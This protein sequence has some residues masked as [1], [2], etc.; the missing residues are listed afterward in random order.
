MDAQLVAETVQR[1]FGRLKIKLSTPVATALSGHSVIVK[2]ISLPVM[3]DAELAESIHW[4]A[5]QYI[6]FRYRRRE[7]RLSDPRRLQPV[8]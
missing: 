2:R 6:P 3:S 8:R 1:L 7:P 5:E 4:E